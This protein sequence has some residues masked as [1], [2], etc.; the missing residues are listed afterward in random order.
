MLSRCTNPKATDFE[1]YGGRR[2]EVTGRW[3]SF[4]N[5]F[6]DMGLR[7]EGTTL[8]RINNDGNYEPGNCRWA[9]HKQQGQNK[10]KRQKGTPWKKKLKLTPRI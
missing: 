4:G 1:Y 10:R 5:F 8:D 7:P 6:Q 2:I 3:L 9:T